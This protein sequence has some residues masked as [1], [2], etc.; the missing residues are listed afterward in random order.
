MYYCQEMRGASWQ[1][2]SSKA[3]QVAISFSKEWFVSMWLVHP[4]AWFLLA[5]LIA[6]AL[7]KSLEFQKEGIGV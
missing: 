4:L 3:E 2:K 7:L 5:K 1:M 6:M